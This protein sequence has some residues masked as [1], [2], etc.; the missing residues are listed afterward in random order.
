MP[1]AR[2]Q[3]KKKNE[4]KRN[5]GANDEIKEEKEGKIDPDLVR[6]QEL[7]RPWYI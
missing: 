5:G 6:A 4:E 7:H 2:K 1:K 3:G